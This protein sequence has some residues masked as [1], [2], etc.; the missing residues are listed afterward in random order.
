[1]KLRQFP[2]SGHFE[3]GEDRAETLQIA[4]PESEAERAEVASS[5]LAEPEVTTADSARRDYRFRYELGDYLG[6]GL[7]RLRVDAEDASGRSHGAE[8]TAALAMTAAA[9]DATEGGVERVPMWFISKRH[10]FKRLDRGAAEYPG[11]AYGRLRL[12]DV[13]KLPQRRLFQARP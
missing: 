12:G 7:F 11:P 4:V 1:M 6:D 10:H 9:R 2:F 13:E 3:D 8:V 5:I